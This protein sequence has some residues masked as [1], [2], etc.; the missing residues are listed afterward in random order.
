[1]YLS[2]PPNPVLSSHLISLYLYRQNNIWWQTQIIKP[3]ITH[4][5]QSPLTS[6]HLGPNVSLVTTFS[7]PNSYKENAYRTQILKI[8]ELRILQVFNK[9]LPHSGF[10]GL[11][12]SVLA[13]GT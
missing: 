11:V 13:S 3:I 4:S 6:S 8:L 10:S 5:L 7:S 12:V 1:M 2:C 9:R